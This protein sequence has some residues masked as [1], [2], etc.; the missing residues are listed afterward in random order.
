MLKESV[1][2]VGITDTLMKASKLKIIR[3]N[4]KYYG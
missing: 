2:T 1:L 3:N 4:I